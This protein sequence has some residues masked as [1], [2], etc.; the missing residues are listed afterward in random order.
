MS[1]N[2]IDLSSWK[3]RDHYRHFSGNIRCTYS[4]TVNI[5]IDGLAKELKRRELKIYIAQIYMI[6]CVAN[7]YTE[8]KMG[9]SSKGDVGYWDVVC[10]SFTVFN[11]SSETFSNIYVPYISNFFAFYEKCN[12]VISSY[13]NSNA[14]FPQGD[15][16]N[17]IFTISSLPWLEFTGFNLNIDCEEIYLPPIFTIGRFCMKNGGKHMP[18]SIQVHHG[19]CDGYHVGQF[20]ESLQKMASNFVDWL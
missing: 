7:M 4:V 9:I 6:S 14:L 13:V 19:V 15:M 5:D 18:L 10:P 16:P 8:F 11:R 20:T 1:F 2:I 3:R 17:N 12:R